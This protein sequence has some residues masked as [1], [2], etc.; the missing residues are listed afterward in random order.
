MNIS[1]LRELQARDVVDISSTLRSVEINPTELCNRKCVFCPRVDPKLYKNQKKHITAE[2]CNVIGSQLQDFNFTGRIGFVGFGEPLLHPNL[3]ECI[4]QIKVCKSAQWV[5]INTNGDF[6][7]R[8]LAVQLAKAG[9]TNITIS[10]YDSDKSEYFKDILKGI[11]V[12]VVFRHHYNTDQNYNLQLV[13]RIDIIK[14]EQ[15]LNIDRECYVPFYKMFIDWN[16]DYLLCQQ[17]WGKTT[18]KYNIKTTTIKEFWVDKLNFYRRPL[19]NGKRHNYP[20]STC[21]IN[22]TVHG[23]SSFD[24][25]KETIND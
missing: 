25:L 11:N 1:N 7:T 8:E 16:G 12:E 2:L 14:R 10:M 13:N 21:N 15:I 9:C 19:I 4:K 3:V 6:L 18:N 5:E 17:D 24:I 22:G 23:K 20:C